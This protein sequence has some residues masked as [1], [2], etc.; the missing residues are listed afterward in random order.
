MKKP[1][2]ILISFV[3]VCLSSC[4]LIVHKKCN[5]QTLTEDLAILERRMDPTDFQNLKNGLCQ[6]KLEGGDINNYTYN[7]IKEFWSHKDRNKIR[8]HDLQLTDH[9]IKESFSLA[10]ELGCENWKSRCSDELFNFTKSIWWQKIKEQDE[11]ILLGIKL[12]KINDTIIEAFALDS[13]V[14]STTPVVSK[15]ELI[16][17]LK[18]DLNQKIDSLRSL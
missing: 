18:E 6:I 5:E 11:V 1:F 15:V 9:S 8:K 12:G 10:G 7:E 16:K 13:F 14:V 2:F 4:D 3:A 17:S